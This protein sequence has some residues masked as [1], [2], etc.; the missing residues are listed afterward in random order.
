ME[1]LNPFIHGRELAPNEFIG[2]ERELR[3][4]YG[5]MATRTS[6]AVIGQPRMGKTSLLKYIIH[7]ISRSTDLHSSLGTLVF[8]YLDGHPL[9]GT[10]GHEQF[11]Q[12]AI[13]PIEPLLPPNPTLMARYFHVQ[14][15]LYRDD[16]LALLF[17]ELASI[18]HRVVLLL[19][20]FDAFLSHPLLNDGAFFG[21]LRSL[22]SSSAG[23]S[24]VIATRSEMNDLNV[25]TTNFNP[26]G[27]PYFNT[28]QFV[29]MGPLSQSAFD[30][31][32]SKGRDYFN[33]ADYDYIAAV[34]GR[35]PYLSQVAAA[36][37]FA[38]Q[39]D[40]LTGIRRYRTSAEHLRD[41]L[42]PQFDDQWRNWSSSAKKVV[43]AIAL[44]QIPTLIGKHRFETHSTIGD[45]EYYNQEL[46]I[47]K[48]DGLLVQDAS[49]Q[50][51]ISQDAFLWWLADELR[52]HLRDDSSFEDWLRSHEMEGFMTH[53][54]RLKVKE[55]FGAV[56]VGS[57][58]LIEAAAKGFGGGAAK[59]VFPGAE[60]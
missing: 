27:S 12:R 18:G 6:V 39:E 58:A 32:L 45:V 24:L 56:G 40:G 16:A 25:R 31:L 53:E 14:R 17:D 23:L 42:R 15:E 41:N 33:G 5:H 22:S 49:D 8:S 60:G 28:F 54:K 7:A 55:A 46:D 26:N 44:S 37:V 57:K 35:H 48:A 38:A 51:R 29:R 47:L 21:V 1:Q 50:W 19:D 2:R 9:G 34:S 10:V 52:T 11:W 43:T 4:I 36:S 59:A 20:E 30:Q 13:V 3:Q